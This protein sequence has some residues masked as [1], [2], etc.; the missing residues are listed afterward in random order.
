MQAL[1][2]ISGILVSMKFRNEPINIFTDSL[3]SIYA[4]RS[5]T[6]KS[7]LPLQTAWK[8][9]NLSRHNPDLN[10]R[11]VKA[12][13]GTPGNEAADSLAKLGATSLEP[14]RFNAAKSKT[15]VKNKIEKITVRFQTKTLGELHDLLRQ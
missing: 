1:N 11:W 9:Q 5:P 13:V 8:L 12:H 3:S 15:W 14:S 10:V 7:Y 6:Y 2:F 4:L